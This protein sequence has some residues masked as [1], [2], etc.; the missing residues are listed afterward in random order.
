MT[1]TPWMV[2]T[3][4]V[5]PKNPLPRYHKPRTS[6]SQYS[7]T[8]H[9]RRQNTQ[10]EIFISKIHHKNAIYAPHPARP[11]RLCQPPWTYPSLLKPSPS[12]AEPTE[13]SRPSR[14][15]ATLRERGSGGEALLLEKRPLPQNLPNVVFRGGSAREGT[16]L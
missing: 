10:L 12:Q 6:K 7:T 2:K 11:R 15:P 5:N 14:T 16:F 1:P 3:A 8:H 9:F 4:R 13:Q